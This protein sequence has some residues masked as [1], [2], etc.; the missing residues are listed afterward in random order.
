MPDKVTVRHKFYLIDKIPCEADGLIGLDFLRAYNANI[1]LS[2]NQITLHNDYTGFELEL[3][4]LHD[5]E[6]CTFSTATSNVDRVKRLLGTL[7]LNYLNLEEQKTIEQI[8]A[9]YADIF[10][11][12]DMYIDIH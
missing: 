6:L 4:P 3:E 5:Y 12:K 11:C 7:N 1:D 10:Y 2:T 8:C 9:K